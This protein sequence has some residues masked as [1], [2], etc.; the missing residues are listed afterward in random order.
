MK[1]GMLT[2]KIINFCRAKDI[3]NNVHLSQPFL[4][5]LNPPL[6]V[7]NNF[8]NKGPNVKKISDILQELF[9]ALNM[10]KV[11]PEHLKRVVSFTYNDKN[12]SIY[13]RNYRVKLSPVGVSKSIQ[14][15]LESK[16]INFSDYNN[17]SQYIN[18]QGDSGSS[19]MKQTIKLF[20]VG[21]RLKLKFFKYDAT[22]DIKDLPK[23]EE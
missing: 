13:F 6:L 18:A 15:I 14:E 17:F 20:E 21:P 7:L 9:P 4:R 19:K 5:E 23:D 1:G 2:F 12:Q 16:T 10:T 22:F 11:K 8:N 3:L